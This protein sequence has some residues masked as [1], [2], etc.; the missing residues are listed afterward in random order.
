MKS[1]SKTDSA[2]K[3]ENFD[4]QNMVRLSIDSEIKGKSVT[5][6]GK[7]QKR[8]NFT[9]KVFSIENSFDICKNFI[10]YFPHNNIDAL[11]KNFKIKKIFQMNEVFPKSSLVPH[12]SPKSRKN[13]KSFF[14]YIKPIKRIKA[15][16]LF[17]NLVNSINIGLKKLKNLKKNEIIG[18]FKNKALDIKINRRKTWD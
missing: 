18:N 12:L 2:N 7:S 13:N 6:S 9:N 14:N 11:V 3:F 1:K 5:I 8:E 17:K 15:R 10:N 4:N 16:F